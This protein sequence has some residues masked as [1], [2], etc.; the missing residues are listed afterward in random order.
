MT[1]DDLLSRIDSLLDDEEIDGLGDWAYGWTDAMRWTPMEAT[2]SEAVWEEPDDDP[3]DSG[4]DHH[5]DSQIHVIPAEHVAEWTAW[6]TNMPSAERG[7]ISWY[8]V[9][10]TCGMAGERSVS[11][12]CTRDGGSWAPAGQKPVEPPQEYVDSQMCRSI[13]RRRPY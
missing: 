8:V 12:G 11:C 2:Q 7:D 6:L 5:P 1:T 3:L 13:S 10:F 9:C 4:W